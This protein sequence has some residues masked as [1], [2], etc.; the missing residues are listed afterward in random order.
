MKF[1]QSL[2]LAV[3]AGLVTGLSTASAHITVG[4]RTFGVIDNTTQS[5]NTQTVTGSFGW[6]DATDDSYGDSHR[7]R[8]FKFTLGSTQTVSLTVQRNDVG[9]Q[10]GAFGLFLPAFSLYTTPFFPASATHDFS[11]PTSNYL[12]GLFGTGATGES[13]TDTG[14]YVSGVFTNTPNSLWDVGESFVDGNGNGVYDGPGI[15]GSGKE[16]AL[17]ALSPWKI[18]NDGGDE[19]F[20]NAIIGHAADGT[21]ANYGSAPGI[22][23]DGTADGTV[24][25]TFSN[26][27]AGDYYFFVGGANYAA[28]NTEAPIYG[29]TFTSFPSY[30]IGVAISATPEPTSAALLALSATGLLMR[31]P[32]RRQD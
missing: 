5:N 30:G 22:N 8:A 1:H 28:Q 27:A 9:G 4:G 7:L 31:R 23:G 2:F 32:R 12:T 10:T 15:G 24:S 26:L 19:L 18:Y 17:R 14:R 3:T 25:A 29:P 6:A 20:F 11:V 21:P 16:G 13:F